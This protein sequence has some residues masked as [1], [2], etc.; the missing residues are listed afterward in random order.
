MSA[1]VRSP[2]AAHTGIISML[3]GMDGTFAH[4]YR[5]NGRPL[6]PRRPGAPVCAPPRTL[7]GRGPRGGR[8]PPPPACAR[9]ACLS[10][11]LWG[12]AGAA[13]TQVSGGLCPSVQPLPLG[14]AS[15]T[16]QGP[17]DGGPPQVPPHL[18][19]AGAFEHRQDPPTPAAA[20]TG[21]DVEVETALPHRRPVPPPSALLPP[22]LRSASRGL[23]GERDCRAGWRPR[24]RRSSCRD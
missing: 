19:D 10:G 23:N 22:H 20:W 5:R 12:P 4:T 6:S 11:G 16:G 17:G 18:L 24:G 7:A 9:T 8:G 14:R 15:C 21:E 1:P 2:L 3:L 13:E